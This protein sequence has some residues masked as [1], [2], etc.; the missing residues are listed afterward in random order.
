MLAAVRSM[1]DYSSEIS[2]LYRA[3]NNY[4]SRPAPELYVGDFALLY[5]PS[6][7]RQIHGKYS[8]PFDGPWICTRV[9]TATIGPAAGHPNGW[10]DW[11]LILA[12]HSDA[13]PKVDSSRTVS[14]QADR[15][16]LLPKLPGGIFNE[17]HL[18]ASMFPNHLI[19]EVVGG[20]F[21]PSPPLPSS[22]SSPSNSSSNASS[23]SSSLALSSSST[24]SAS[25]SFSLLVKWTGVALPS[26]VN[27][28][29]LCD[30]PAHKGQPASSTNA[31]V[32]QF[33]KHAGL[34]ASGRA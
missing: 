7:K 34:D 25:S 29:S 33:L 5:D 1:A 2:K 15:V 4:G 16:R 3:C 8:S 12:G 21:Y 6:E 27:F 23:S 22:N 17:Y 11:Q 32:R 18:N 31:F 10:S 20:P 30:V 14:C 24:P 26:I 19:K 13:S 9:H 28:D